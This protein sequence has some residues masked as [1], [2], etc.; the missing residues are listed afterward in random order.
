M[1][2]VDV[3]LVVVL[4]SAAEPA[5]GRHCDRHHHPQHREG[6]CPCHQIFAPGLLDWRWAHPGHPGLWLH[7]GGGECCGVVAMAARQIVI[8]SEDGDSAYHQSSPTL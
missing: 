8:T 6:G 5:A 1:L 3:V 7:P 4:Y 2:P